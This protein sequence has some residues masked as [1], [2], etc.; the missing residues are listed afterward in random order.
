[1]LHTSR[2][3]VGK[4]SAQKSFGSPC[5][6]HLTTQQVYELIARMIAYEDDARKHG[7]TLASGRFQQ[8]SASERQLFRAELIAEYIRLAIRRLDPERTDFESALEAFCK[9]IC[10]TEVPSLELMGTFLAAL[11]IASRDDRLN[12]L[13]EVRESLQRT[14][15]LALQR[16]SDTLRAS[17]SAQNKR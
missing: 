13:P 8:L 16:C 9:K 1:M 12:N 6:A 11:D 17:E 14:M 15:V 4:T 2:D 10:E 7:V 5:P 3:A